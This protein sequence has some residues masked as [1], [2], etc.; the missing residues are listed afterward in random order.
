MVTSCVQNAGTSLTPNQLQQARPLPHHQKYLQRLQNPP[1]YHHQ[2]NPK[3]NITLGSAVLVERAL[4]WKVLIRLFVH[5]AR[6]VS[7]VIVK[8]WLDLGKRKIE[9][10]VCMALKPS[11]LC[12]FVGKECR[13]DMH[14]QQPKKLMG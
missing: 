13:G 7:A 2:P 4:L 3:Q 10:M 5:F 9:C 14:P 11:Q 1:Q 8:S 12:R 6:T